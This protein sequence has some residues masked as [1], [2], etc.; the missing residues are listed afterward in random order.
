MRIEYDFYGFAALY[1]NA[2]ALRRIKL[3]FGDRF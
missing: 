1:R 3:K 2:V